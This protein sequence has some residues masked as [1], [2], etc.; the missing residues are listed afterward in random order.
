MTQT[1]L[2]DF[3]FINKFRF[4]DLEKSTKIRETRLQS[5]LP[6]F[7]DREYTCPISN[8]TFKNGY[9]HKKDCLYRYCKGGW[10]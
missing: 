10:N 6:D 4:L 7:N 8:K 5:E 9:L 2:N 1:F 3:G